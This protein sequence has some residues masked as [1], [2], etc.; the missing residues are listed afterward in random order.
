MS[1]KRVCSALFNGKRWQIGFGM[2]GMTNGKVDDGVC[3]YHSK[4]IVIHRKVKGRVVSL[5]EATIHECAHAA[6]PMI[7]EDDID[8]FAAATSKVLAKMKDA[9]SSK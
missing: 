1:F 2:T 4:R 5:E 7:M 6:F 9:E 8:R 3:R